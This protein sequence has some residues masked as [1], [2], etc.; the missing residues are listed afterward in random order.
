MR[1]RCQILIAV[2]LG[3]LLGASAVWLARERSRGAHVVLE[4]DRVIAELHIDLENA[5]RARRRYT[6]T[7]AEAPDVILRSTV[8]H[9]PLD[10]GES[11]RASVTL[12]A[13]RSSFRDGRRTFFVRIDDDAGTQRILTF[14]VELP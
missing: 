2:I 12:D 7:L 4:N 9:V 8:A 13:P 1:E 11:T 3:G 5:T 10:P 6:I 14:P